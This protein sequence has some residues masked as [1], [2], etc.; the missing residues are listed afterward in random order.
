MIQ[1]PLT[2]ELEIK[3]SL[4]ASSSMNGFTSGLRDVQRRY[5]QA[6]GVPEVCL[7]CEL[8]RWVRPCQGQP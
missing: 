8:Q 2:A 3:G 1:R 7:A 6:C 4:F 5:R